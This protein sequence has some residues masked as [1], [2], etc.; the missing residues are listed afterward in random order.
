[1]TPFRFGSPGRVLFG[2]YHAAADSGRLVRAA[3][4]CNPFGQEAI[5]IHRLYRVLADR[6]ARDG[7]HVLRF[8]YFATGESD[9]A[10]AEGDMRGWIEDLLVANTELQHRS[11]CS[12]VLWCGIRLGGTLAAMAS[13]RAT[14]SP[15]GLLLWD[16]VIDGRHY[17]EQLAN[18]H[19]RMI[20]QGFDRQPVGVELRP[21]NEAL[22]F[23]MGAE[24]N[25]QLLALRPDDLL[26]ARARRISIVASPQDESLR[27]A[28]KFAS[29][30]RTGVAI[31]FEHQFEWASPD[32]MNSALVPPAALQLL[33]SQI[34]ESLQ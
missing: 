10:D 31:P 32:A 6:L 20:Q 15:D 4:L 24:M 25:R 23:A 18:D 8:D 16:P 12:Q 22:G 26:V 27:L 34:T 29:P 21:A 9:G 7:I 14:P 11:S 13:A 3:L 1:M 30:D 19:A 17:R 2:A 5:R 33:L 28:E